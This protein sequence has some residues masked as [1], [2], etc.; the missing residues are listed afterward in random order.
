MAM[1]AVTPRRWTADD[2]RALPDEP[3]KRFECVDGEL[4]ASPGPRLAHQAMVG[5]LWRALDLFVRAQ[6]IGAVF[7]APGDIELDAFTLVQPDVFILPLVEGRSPRDAAEIG[8]PLLFVEVLS[9]S[10]ARFDRVVKR[11]RYQR[12]GVEYWIVDLDARV[13]ERW[14]PASDRPEIVTESITWQPAGAVSALV[15]ELG[16]V[17]VEAVGE[18]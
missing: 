8:F 5:A 16:P 11:G 14:T 9:P 3:G 7:M 10:T 17:F 4:L 15:L 6:R 13:V 2:V 1:P 12:Y 18:I